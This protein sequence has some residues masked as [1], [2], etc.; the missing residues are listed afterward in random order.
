MYIIC[1]HTQDGAGTEILSLY[2]P[3]A[4]FSLLVSVM[5]GPLSCFR[6]FSDLSSSLLP[7]PDHSGSIWEHEE[8][9][10]QRR[11]ESAL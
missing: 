2:I 6:H 11:R 1:M 9:G 3:S 5:L 8:A 4:I 10:G 7:S